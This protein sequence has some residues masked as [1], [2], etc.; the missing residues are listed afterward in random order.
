MRSCFVCQID[1]VWG[2]LNVIARGHGQA[3]VQMDVAWGVDFEELKDMP[4]DDSF[5]MRV[6]EYYSDFRNKSS[7]TI[8]TC[9]RYPR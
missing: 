8:N 6:H 9:F 7:I 4:T 3:L 5:E 2:H 1:A